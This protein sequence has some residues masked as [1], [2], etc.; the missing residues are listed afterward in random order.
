MSGD[1]TFS[2]TLWKKEGQTCTWLYLPGSVDEPK[3][4]VTLMDVRTI[5]AIRGDCVDYN[6]PSQNLVGALGRIAYR[7]VDLATYEVDAHVTLFFD[8]GDS[9][10]AETVRY[11]ADGLRTN[12]PCPEYYR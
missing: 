1:L 7:H 3:H 6:A 8:G 10:A 9:G 4:P 2:I 12:G 11:D 5:E